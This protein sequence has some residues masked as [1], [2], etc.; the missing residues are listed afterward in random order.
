MPLNLANHLNISAVQPSQLLLVDCL[1]LWLNNQ[2]YHQPDQNLDQ[3]RSALVESVAGF[4]GRSQSDLLL[5]ANEV[6]LGVVPMGEVSR[7]F[8][9]QA[10]WLNQALAQVAD[11]VTFV[12]AG[13]P[14]TFKDNETLKHQ[15]HVG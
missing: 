11:Q 3:M 1:T 5:V 6:G 4:C 10:G 2:L 12:A 9:D 8:V 13:L 14:M 15:E 7:V